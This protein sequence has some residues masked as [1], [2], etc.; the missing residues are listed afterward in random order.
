ME[1]NSDWYKILL[2]HKLVVFDRPD[3]LERGLRF[4]DKPPLGA[5]FLFKFPDEDI[6]TF[7]TEGMK[8]PIDI[9]FFDSDKNLVHEERNCEPDDRFS[10]VFTCKYVVEIPRGRNFV[11]EQQV[12][13]GAIQRAQ[14]PHVTK[15]V[16]PAPDPYAD[17]MKSKRPDLWR[18]S[19][20]TSV[21]AKVAEFDDRKNLN[22]GR[23]S[24]QSIALRNQA[25]SIASGDPRRAMMLINQALA[26][27]G[28]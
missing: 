23:V 11:S 12:A 24:P 16:A 2:G 14:V 4:Y 26:N 27:M 22:P 1:N 19:L 28:V 13:P 5:A 7:T 6:R 20:I 9:F 15:P 25:K 3:E 17:V 10:S 21:E 8:F 18:K